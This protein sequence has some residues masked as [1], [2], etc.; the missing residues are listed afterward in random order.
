M[1]D[2]RHKLLSTPKAVLSALDGGSAAARLAG[3]TPQNMTNAL[4]RNRLPPSTF[5]IFTE[6][7]ARRGFCAPSQLWGIKPLKKR[8]SNTRTHMTAD[9]AQRSGNRARRGARHSSEESG[10]K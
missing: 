8:R 9:Y 6:E 2:S 5:L 4:A 1:I 7:L 3:C 10:G